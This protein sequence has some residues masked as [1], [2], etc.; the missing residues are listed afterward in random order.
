MLLQCNMTSHFNYTL[1]KRK[2][3]E[4]GRLTMVPKSQVIHYKLEI[5]IHLK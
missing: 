3:I 2:E 4:T 5:T 1:N